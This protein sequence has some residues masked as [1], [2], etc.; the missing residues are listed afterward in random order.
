MM[1]KITARILEV[2]KDDQKICSARVI[3]A[4]L[5]DEKSKQVYR[6]QWAETPTVIGP[7]GTW[8]SRAQ[9]AFIKAWERCEVGNEVWL[10]HAEDLNLN[11][12]EPKE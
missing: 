6:V 3:W 7:T 1:K 5:E 11:F 9:Y 2:T 12:F 10:Y 4:K 8:S